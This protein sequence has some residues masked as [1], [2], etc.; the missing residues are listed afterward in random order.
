MGS[1]FFKHFGKI[2]YASTVILAGKGRH[3][4]VEFFVKAIHIDLL[5]RCFCQA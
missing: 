4:G 1:V 3:T 2:L 5:S